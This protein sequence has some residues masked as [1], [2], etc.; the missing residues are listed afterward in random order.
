M[1]NLEFKA[2]LRDLP[3]ARAIAA[4]EFG[5][6]IVETMLQLDTYYNVA[7]GRLKRR[8]I[9]ITV[10]PNPA[11]L[12]KPP[13]PQPDEIEWIPYHRPDKLGPKISQYQLLTDEQARERFGD[14]PLPELGVV[15]KVREVHMTERPGS[16]AAG[17]RIHLDRVEK[18]GTFI[19]FEA[20]VT[21]ARPMPRCVAA[22]DA[23]RSAF[24]PVMGEPISA[25]YADLLSIR[26]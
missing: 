5:A 12:F 22:L 10:E 11:E 23:L 21:P 25:G 26:G 9:W 3:I 24:A 16:P 6:I 7:D 19:E 17:V 14:R 1:Q 13:R 2:E 18:L 20:L 8:D 15:R 4:D